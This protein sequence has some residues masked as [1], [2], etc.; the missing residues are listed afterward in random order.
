MNISFRGKQV[1][2]GE[3][4]HGFYVRGR[5]GEHYIL[6]EYN[7]LATNAYSVDGETVGRYT[8]LKDK[9]GTEIFEGDV[10]GRLFDD[11]PE[12]TIVCYK[13]GLLCAKPV[14]R[15]KYRPLNI[16]Q[17]VGWIPVTSK[18]RNYN[19][20]IIG[21]KHDNPELLAGGFF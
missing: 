20:T 12:N 15:K 17:G 18:N 4:Y 14:G 3:W 11:Y 19:F 13:G 9:H 7:G 6:S 2:S 10:M 5:H 16:F 1:D 21:N 8:G